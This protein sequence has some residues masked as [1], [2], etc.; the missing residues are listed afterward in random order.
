M[1][2]SLFSCQSSPFGTKKPLVNKRIFKV[3][4]SPTLK[5]YPLILIWFF[6][7]PCKLIFINFMDFLL[8][9]GLFMDKST[10]ALSA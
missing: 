10:T 3:R 5:I 1:L 8:K 6:I 9:Y 2:F 4:Q 7:I